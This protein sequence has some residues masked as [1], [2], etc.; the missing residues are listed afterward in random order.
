MIGNI[1]YVIGNRKIFKL[2]VLIVFMTTIEEHSKILKEFVDDINEKIN[3][4]LLYERQKIIGFSASEASANLFAI[5]FHRLNL[6][7]PGFNVNHRDFSSLKSAEEKY[8]FDFEGKSEIFRFLVNQENF[9]N[10]LCYGKDK[11]LKIVKE[12]ISNFFELKN[13]ILEEGH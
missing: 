4:N 6:I 11:E 2:I 8:P 10:K 13:I 3:A 7:E 9:R 12:A 1:I 5:L